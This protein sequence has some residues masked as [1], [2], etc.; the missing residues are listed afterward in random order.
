MFGFTAGGLSIIC[1]IVDALATTVAISF[2]AVIITTITIALSTAYII[3]ISTIST[4]GPNLYFTAILQFF[5]AQVACLV[6]LLV[7]DFSAE[8]IK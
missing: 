8:P 5:K 7:F 4:I 3:T 1:I 6:L 2:T